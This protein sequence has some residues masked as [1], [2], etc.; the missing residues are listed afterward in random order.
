MLLLLK[1]NDIVK[2]TMPLKVGEHK[3]KQ[4]L[5]ISV[6][7]ITARPTATVNILDKKTNICKKQYIFQQ[8]S[9]KVKRGRDVYVAENINATFLK[10]AMRLFNL[11][12]ITSKKASDPP[13][14]S[15]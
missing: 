7:T 9:A 5:N 1:Q 14:I 13:A 15:S 4:F 2:P 11:Q 8:L 12:P 10:S 6:I 3:N